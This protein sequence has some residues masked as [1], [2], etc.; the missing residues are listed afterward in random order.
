MGEK[1]EPREPL[2]EPDQDSNR[3]A[4][5]FKTATVLKIVEVA[6]GLGT[7]GDAHTLQD[8]L[9]TAALKFAIAQAWASF[10]DDRFS[11]LSK[12][13]KATRRVLKLI[14]GDENASELDAPKGI[15]QHVLAAFTTPQPGKE[16]DLNEID[17]VGLDTDLEKA[18]QLIAA[19]AW[20]RDRANAARV[21]LEKPNTQRMDPRLEYSIGSTPEAWLICEALPEIY[22][23]HFRRFG[24]STTGPGVRFIQHCL[25]AVGI[26]KKPDAIKRMLV[27][28]RAQGDIGA[29]RQR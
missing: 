19:A 4:F 8:G 29:D 15:P 27:R 18:Q 2:V 11:Y 3:D 7:T 14:A 13:E 21:R 10:P 22:E 9:E 6:G 26:S 12:L 23:Q 16:L 25:A 24:V 20:F 1:T 28:Y 5:Y 17:I